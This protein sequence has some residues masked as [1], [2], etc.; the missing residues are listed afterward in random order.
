M[1]SEFVPA[2]GA[3]GRSNALHTLPPLQHANDVQL[4]MLFPRRC[5][6]RNGTKSIKRKHSRPRHRMPNEA[7]HLIEANSRKVSW[8]GGNSAV[9]NKTVTNPPLL[10]SLLP[11]LATQNTQHWQQLQSTLAMSICLWGWIVIGQWG[12]VLNWDRGGLGWILGRSFS[13]R[14]WWRT[15]QVAQ[16]GCGCPIPAGIQGQA[17]CGSGQP[18]LLVGDPARSRGLELDEHCGPFQP[19]PFYDSTILPPAQDPGAGTQLV[20]HAHIPTVLATALPHATTAS[21]ASALLSMDKHLTQ[22]STQL[23]SAI[24][25]RFSWRYLCSSIIW[26]QAEAH[27]V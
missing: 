11:F 3:R 5:S 21:Q 16:G 7:T 12:M 23:C 14:G 6:S 15:E 26:T 4:Q 24:C 18:G 22:I 2:T 25:S 17:G 13:P 8:E 19:R 10:M 1:R 27:V 9:P 20:G